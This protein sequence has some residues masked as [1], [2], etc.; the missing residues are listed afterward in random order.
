M[1]AERLTIDGLEN[2]WNFGAQWRVVDISNRHAVVDLCSCTGEPLERLQTE[3]PT[4]IA[5]LR[6][7]H[8][9]GR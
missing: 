4:V 1:T 6:T 5:Y 7:A 8:C 3:D 2:W 9:N